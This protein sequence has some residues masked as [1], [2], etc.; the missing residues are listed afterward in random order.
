[1][2]ASE[3]GRR[4]GGCQDCPRMCG[5]DRSS[6]AGFCGEGGSLRV[7][8]ACL[9]FGEEPLLTVEGGSGT[10]FVTGCNLRCAFCQNYQ[11]SQDG[12][13]RAV[14]SREFADI[15]LRLQDAGAENVNVVT[16]S[17]HARRIAEGLEIARRDGLSLPVCWN[18]S[19][20]DSVG[21]LEMLDGLVSIWLP[22][23]KTLSSG[24]SGSLC[25]AADYPEV[26]KAA[27]E[28]MISKSPLEIVEKNGREKI[29]S[30]VIVRHLF[31]PGKFEETAEV[32][33]WLKERVDGRAVVSLMSQYTPVPF[34]EDE[35]TLEARRRRLSA[36]EDRPVSREEDGDLRDLIEAFGFEWLFYQDLCRDTEWLPDFRGVQPFPNKLAR[37]VWHWTK[38]FV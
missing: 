35:R 1:M 13:G 37:P 3:S 27:I 30:G 15:C 29:L 6:A 36:I 32:L 28:Y 26:A 22:D 18:S 9:H 24:L 8:T 14:S 16:G 19:G 10:V 20:Y 33:S 4:D 7:A 2:S 21:S 11:I 25:S 34:D 31:L 17:H 5:V 23:L 12:M 38:G